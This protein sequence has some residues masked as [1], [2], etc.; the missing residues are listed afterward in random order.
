ME[1]PCQKKL[2]LSSY[3]KLRLEMNRTSSKPYWGPILN[4]QSVSFLNND[5]QRFFF[6]WPNFE[7]SKNYS[8]ENHDIFWKLRTR[9]FRCAL[10]NNLTI[11]RGRGRQIAMWA[12]PFL[13]WIFY[14]GVSIKHGGKM[15]T[16][17]SCQPLHIWR[18][19]SHVVLADSKIPT[20]ITQSNLKFGSLLHWSTGGQKL[21]LVSWV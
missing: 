4:L 2:T 10:H 5:C 18:L 9:A 13:S 15:T 6:P 20:L 16:S 21:T 1:R 14:W 3:C 17:K 12:M 7:Q 19:V 8:I 11:L